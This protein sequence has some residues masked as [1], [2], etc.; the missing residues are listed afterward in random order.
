MKIIGRT[1]DPNNAFI[2]HVP[3]D[4]AYK[5]LGH[6]SSYASEKKLQVG[7]TIKI[8]EM[9]DRLT[10]MKRNEAELEKTASLLRASADLLD[11]ALP[12]IHRANNKEKEESK[13]D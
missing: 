6:Y 12:G 7:D 9:Y 5:L 11:K 2:M 3:E 4:E 8:S 13:E 10:K 1:G